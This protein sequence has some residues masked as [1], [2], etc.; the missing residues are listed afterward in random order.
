MQLDARMQCS[1]TILNSARTDLNRINA[2]LHYAGIFNDVPQTWWERFELTRAF[3][4][5]PYILIGMNT[6]LSLAAIVLSTM[7]CS[8]LWSLL[9]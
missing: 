6:V 1:H 9:P 7:L 2:T 8:E 4:I 3:N 5:I